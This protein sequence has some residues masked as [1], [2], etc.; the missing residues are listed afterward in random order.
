MKFHFS[1]ISLKFQH[2]Y[3]T[4]GELRDSCTSWN[5][6]LLKYVSLY[7]DVL[8]FILHLG[9]LPILL[10]QFCGVGA[11]QWFVFVWILIFVCLFHSSM[12][13]FKGT[14]WAHFDVLSVGP[15]GLPHQEANLLLLLPRA[16]PQALVLICKPSCCPCTVLIGEGRKQRTLLNALFCLLVW[17]F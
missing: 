14:V 9:R 10:H 5:T 7:V 3:G 16:D 6:R 4:G 15:N 11:N 12:P 13:A 2:P 1:E 8:P 17:R